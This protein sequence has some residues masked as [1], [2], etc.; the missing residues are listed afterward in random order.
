MSDL[1]QYIKDICRD[2]GIDVDVRV[3]SY[4]ASM[5]SAHVAVT[6]GNR[7]WFFD[8]LVPDPLNQEEYDDLVWIVESKLEASLALS[9]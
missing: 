9:E 3:L 8:A 6:D 4:E 2:H 1:I 7:R 5:N